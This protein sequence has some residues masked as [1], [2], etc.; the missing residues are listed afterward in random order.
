MNFWCIFFL[1][2]KCQGSL[3]RALLSMSNT[4]AWSRFLCWLLT[5]HGCTVLFLFCS[6]PCPQ[7]WKP[8]ANDSLTPDYERLSLASRLWNSVF[9]LRV[10][11]WI[12]HT[13]C[14]YSNHRFPELCLQAYLGSLLSSSMAHVQL[15][16]CLGLCGLESPV[17]TFWNAQWWQTVEDPFCG[18]IT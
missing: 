1:H 15:N 10:V 7:S 14:S 5:G 3:R 12:Q 11:C 6:F 2:K 4:Q 13:L 17:E 18:K 9:H 16:P 8:K